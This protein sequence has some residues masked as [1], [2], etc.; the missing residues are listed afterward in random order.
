M[1]TA[2]EVEACKSAAGFVDK[3]TSFDTKEL[4]SL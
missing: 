4:H 2:L 3:P 1:A